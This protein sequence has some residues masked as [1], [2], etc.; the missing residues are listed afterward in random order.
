MSNQ[1]EMVS[2]LDQ[3]VASTSGHIVLF[4]A[5]VPRMVP[6]SL[7]QECMAK[8]CAPVNLAAAPR[9]EDVSRAKVEF[10]GDIRRTMLFLAVK[11]LAEENDSKKF[12]AGG[13]PKTAVVSG[14]L[15]FEINRQEL[16]SVYQQYSSAKAENLHVPLHP[17]AE[18]ALAVISAESK[19][20]LLDLAGEIGVDNFDKLKGMQVRDLR[21]T[22]LVKLSGAAL[23]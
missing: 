12:D 7:V 14:M 23:G 17:S 1:V 18:R 11:S 16:V 9:L 10:Q 20:E 5:N 2:L 21:K 6:A 19:D 22:L 13:Y 8:G 3:R 15:G 4:Q